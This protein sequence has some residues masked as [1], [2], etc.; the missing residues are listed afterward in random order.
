MFATL[1]SGLA[2]LASRLAALVGLLSA[3]SFATLSSTV[4]ATV[5]LSS[6]LSGHFRFS[7]SRFHIF[8]YYHNTKSQNAPIFLQPIYK[9]QIE[10]LKGIKNA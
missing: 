8:I 1:A 10:R 6:F 9:S 5:S 2:T 4:S 7:S 3:I